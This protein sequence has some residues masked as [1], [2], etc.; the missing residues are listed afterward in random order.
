MTR[1]AL[2]PR[3]P[4]IDT[5]RKNI[6][7]NT[8][9]SLALS[10]LLVACG[11]SSANQ[12]TTNATA[13]ADSAK[14]DGFVDMFENNS[15]AGWKGDTTY[16]HMKDGILKGEIREDQE[17]LKNNTFLIWQGGEVG[18]F[19]L[20]A[21]FKISEKGNSGINYRSDLF[22][23][24]PNALKG[25]QADI[26]GQNRYTGQNY[27]E[28]KRTTLA[29]RGQSTEILNPTPENKGESK[30][31]AWTN[32]KVIDTIATDQQMQAF[33]KPNDWNEIE[34]RAKGNKLTHLLNGQVIA[35]VTDND[36]QNRKDKGMIG[37]QVHV[38]P[39]MKIEYKDMK[40]KVIEP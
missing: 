14:Q 9:L 13:A 8:Y 31:N 3:K 10:A 18:D 38:G 23:E 6:I 39:P 16:W 35:E 37:V 4:I 26:D 29:Y 5:T 19:E 2:T 24:L 36:T 11:G 22:T 30:G 21:Q 15:L 33:L 25:Y 28:R 34:I 20:K 12:E 32:L 40:I 17:R 27:E 7:K 1:T